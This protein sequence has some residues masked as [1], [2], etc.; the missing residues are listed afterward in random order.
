MMALAAEDAH[1]TSAPTLPDLPLTPG[2]L[3]IQ[4]FWSKTQADISHVQSFC[5]STPHNV[6]GSIENPMAAVGARQHHD[7]HRTVDL[8]TIQREILCTSAEFS[9]MVSNL[10]QHPPPDMP[11]MTMA[12]AMA[13][14]MILT[15]VPMDED[16]KF[17]TEEHRS[18]IDLLTLQ[19]EIQQSI[20][21]I[22]EFFN[23]LQLSPNNIDSNNDQ[24]N[25][26]SILIKTTTDSMMTTPMTQCP[27]TTRTTPTFLTLCDYLRASI[28][29]R[30][31]SL[32]ISCAVLLL[33]DH[34][35]Q[36]FPL[37]NSCQ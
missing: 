15:P 36:D 13:M 27:I 35:S 37:S 23:S 30:T 21:S 34:N 6:Q 2:N 5:P 31:S 18:P 24:S 10:L 29:Q 12:M 8:T 33:L 1:F 3:V 7:S 22:Q 25:G 28:P 32:L 11:Q 20:I 9:T 26:G 4:E 17:I 19:Q 14:A 16:N